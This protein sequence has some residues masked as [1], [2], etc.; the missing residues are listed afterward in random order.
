MFAFAFLLVP[1][2][3][4]NIVLGPC[5]DARV[6]PHSCYIASNN[7]V[8]LARGDRIRGQFVRQ[9][10]IAHE[11]GHAYGQSLS[12]ELGTSEQFANDYED[13]ALGFDRHRKFCRWLRARSSGR[14][15]GIRW[16][17]RRDS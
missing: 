12:P 13:C 4:V 15:L 11:L 5:P 17:E 9:S 14:A 2:V 7:T 3:A 6:Q 8:Y 1:V 10:V 16:L